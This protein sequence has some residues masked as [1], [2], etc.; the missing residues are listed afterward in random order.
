MIAQLR[1]YQAKLLE[2]W[3]LSPEHLL[4]LAQDDESVSCGELLQ[5][6]LCR[7]VHDR[8]GVTALIVGMPVLPLVD[9]LLAQAQPEADRV[10]PL[11]T[12]TRTF[13]HDIPLVRAAELR[14]HG[15]EAIA[16][17][18]EERRGVIVEG[19]G[20]IASGGLTVEQAYVNFSSL[21]HASL[22]KLLLDL[23]R[24]PLPAAED[25]AR[26]QPL[27]AELRKPLAART[28]GLAQ[29]VPQ[30]PALCYES[31]CRAGRRTVELGLVDSFFGNISVATDAA[32]YISQTGAS[33]DRLEDSIELVPND[34]S[35]CAGLTAS[36]ELA[37]HRA[38][39]AATGARTLLHGH[40]RFSVIL[41]LL[42]EETGCR[43][44]DCWRDC[45]RIRRLNGVPV[46]AGEVGAGGLAKSL[47]P[48]IGEKGVA[49]VYGHGV[50]ALGEEDFAT[51]LQAMLALENWCRQNFLQ[52]LT[53][54]LDNENRTL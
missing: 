1:Y 50:F 39:F 15:A 31:I 48:V 4:L 12:E 2:D 27:W 54:R 5:S 53:L 29:I 23:L 32:L 47:P 19:L 37:A 36:S 51:P 52:R 34:D 49:V 11:D 14:L 7:E 8:L 44:G 10:V 9:L 18:L 41:S 33:L 40:P 42:C 17:R 20:L 38:I 30:E 28:E 45:D 24:E 3:L 26:L 25:L 43:T 6:D 16:G 22:V 35:T 21:L 13:L 46:V